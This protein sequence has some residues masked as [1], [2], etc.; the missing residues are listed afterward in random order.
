MM[1][2]PRLA[3]L[4]QSNLRDGLKTLDRLTNLD[5]ISHSSLKQVKKYMNLKKRRFE[6]CYIK[7]SKRRKKPYL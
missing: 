4:Q 6:K 7:I 5:H 1:I 3:S 2:E